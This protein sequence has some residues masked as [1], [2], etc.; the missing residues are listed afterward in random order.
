[1]SASAVAIGAK[2]S[3]K[4]KDKKKPDKGQDADPDEQPLSAAAYSANIKSD[5]PFPVPELYFK[6]FESEIDE[7]E[8]KIRR[9]V[10]K[11]YDRWM[12]QYGRRWPE[13][14]MNTDDL[15]WLAEEA[16]K[17]RL[18]DERGR[19]Y[20][21]PSIGSIRAMLK[22]VEKEAY[23]GEFLEEP[24]DDT[25]GAQPAAGTGKKK[26]KKG[27]A[28]N[29]SNY[30]ATLAGG[31][32]VTDEFESADY[33]AGNLETLWGMPLWDYE[34]KPLMMPDG[35][36]DEAQVSIQHTEQR[37]A[38]CRAAQAQCGAGRRGPDLAARRISAPGDTVCPA[39]T[40]RSRLQRRR[41]AVCAWQRA[42]CILASALLAKS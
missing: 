2:M 18:V 33:E 8:A 39:L 19:P 1:M 4:G 32:W 31:T 24:P 15:V 26:K 37:P 3:G 28:K 9:D 36:P 7:P 10:N 11:L 17:P 16:Y 21:Q 12:E 42:Q 38:R 40:A 29:L 22:P 14:G 34:S 35:P 13:N 6:V 23:P 27:P 41:R 5:T 30:E 20:P 25:P